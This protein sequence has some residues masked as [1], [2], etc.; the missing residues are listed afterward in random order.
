MESEVNPSCF[1][2][3]SLKVIKHGKTSTGNRRYRCRSCGKTWVLEKIQVTRPDLADITEAYLDGKTC[4]DLVSVYHSSPLR[5]NQK[6]REFLDGCPHWEDYLDA[7]VKEHSPRLIYLIGKTFSCSTKESR[8]NSMYV[9]MAIDAL[10]TVVLGY[11]IGQKDS[12]EVWSGLLER[13]HSRGISCQT[14]MSNGNKNIEDTIHR[15]S[16]ES[17]S[18]IFYHRAYRDQEIACCLSRVPIN[19]KL[20]S[21][22]IK[23][24]ESIK[25]QSLNDYLKKR[26]YKRFKEMLLAAPAHFTKRL[27]E[28]IDSRP[29]IRIEGLSSAFQTRFEKFHML[30]DDP[31]PLINGW[32]A[33][34]ML[35][36]LEVGYS[37][38][39]VYIQEPCVTSFKIFSCG[40][41]PILLE[42]KEDSYLLQNFVVEVATRGLQ[43]PL[44][45]SKCE[46]KLEK[47][48]LF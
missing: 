3:S 15:I 46:M 19:N 47:C 32:I 14:Y 1:Y 33:K 38:L 41:M 27:K 37:R 45:Y 22:S 16:P 13:M 23:A 39:A 48:S 20:I 43:I 11:E 8:N 40:Q 2:C 25:N 6:I 34:W 21:D 4:R 12:P 18:R 30:K 17:S 28:R 24:Y 29:R 7:C 31:Y 9:A 26:N 44:F 35:T 42:L 10:S 5:V 36:R